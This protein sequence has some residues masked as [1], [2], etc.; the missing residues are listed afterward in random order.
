MCD[1][2]FR[3][4]LER[5]WDKE[6]FVCVGLDP[7]LNKIPVNHIPNSKFL[8][9][10]QLILVFNQMI[11]DATKDLVCAYKPNIAFYEALGSDGW[12]ALKKTVVYI[13]KVAPDV[14]VILDAKRADIGN[15]NKGYIDMLNLVGADAVTVNPYF[16]AEEGLQPFLDQED[17]GIIVLCRTS[18]KGGS[19]FQDREVLITE[20]EGED[21]EVYVGSGG[22]FDFGGV[23]GII[24]HENGACTPMPYIGPFP[25]F[26]VVAFKVSRE[27]NKNNNCAVVV[28]A[29]CTEELAEVRRIVG[30]MPI[31]IPG[32]GAQGGDIEATVLAGKD[33]RG[34]GM[35]INSSRGII[36]A[37]SGPDFIKAVRRET[38]K[39]R[40]LIKQYR[41]ERGA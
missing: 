1:R 30:D 41:Q 26:E 3:E 37:S 20:E 9:P 10:A 39:L 6:N 4:M 2:N 28:G 16:G 11:I 25:L 15:T 22:I 38:E 35:I 34:K 33:S 32:I 14:P 23:E 36:F 18:N 7:D 40:D 8:T 21:W 5:Q 31:L 29:T 12:F 27:W 24:Q 19:D 13:N 17:K